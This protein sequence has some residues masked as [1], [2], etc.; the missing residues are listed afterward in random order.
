MQ[1]FLPFSASP[2]YISSGILEAH[3]LDNSFTIDQRL[4]HLLGDG[5]QEAYERMRVIAQDEAGRNF[6]ESLTPDELEQISQGSTLYDDDYDELIEN[7]KNW[8]TFLD[9]F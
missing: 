1:L 7:Q 2:N 9:S 4:R 5:S 6:Y 8:K 3:L